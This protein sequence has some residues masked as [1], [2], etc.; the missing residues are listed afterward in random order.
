MRAIENI[1]TN[2][3]YRITWGGIASSLVL[4]SCS[5]KATILNNKDEAI[6]YLQKHKQNT[7]LQHEFTSSYA[8]D[9]IEIEHPYFYYLIGDTTPDSKPIYT[10]QALINGLINNAIR[11]YNPELSIKLKI[12]NDKLIF[13]I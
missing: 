10:K 2:F 8:G 7:K 13:A 5:E 12:Y 9:S 1:I 3:N 6:S 11:D 4:N